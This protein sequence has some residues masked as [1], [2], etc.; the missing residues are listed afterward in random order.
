MVI[1]KKVLFR[2]KVIM[3]GVSLAI[4]FTA[5]EMKLAFQPAVF[6]AGTCAEPFTSCSRSASFLPT[7]EAH[8][9]VRV[10]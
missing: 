3:P 4:S 8:M 10:L 2:K 6:S 5:E 1:S 7:C 9:V